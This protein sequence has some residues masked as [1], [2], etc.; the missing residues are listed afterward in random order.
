MAD[1][2]PCH[3]QAG[4]SNSSQLRDC[5]QLMFLGSWIKII[6]SFTLYYEWTIY[7]L[8]VWGQRCKSFWEERNSLYIL[9]FDSLY[10]NICL[11]EMHSD[12]NNLIW[13]FF[14]MG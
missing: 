5:K 10:G 7:W 14:E 4:M 1:P 9:I 2:A 3:H 6:F 11:S 12:T 8:D 13:Y